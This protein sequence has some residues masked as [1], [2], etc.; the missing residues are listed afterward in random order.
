MI[1]ELL[2]GETIE[3]LIDYQETY[4]NSPGE[5][6]D[7]E[8]VT[9]LIEYYR[10]MGKMEN[11]VWSVIDWRMKHNHTRWSKRGGNHL[12]KKCSGKIQDVTE[13]FITP[14]FEKETVEELY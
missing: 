6:T 9:E 7:I 12:A 3:E 11:H 4:R 8:D 14:V 10:N 2:D 1:M 13:R 5:E